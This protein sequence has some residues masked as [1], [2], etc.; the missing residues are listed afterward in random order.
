MYRIAYSQKKGFTSER[1]LLLSGPLVVRALRPASWDLLLLVT[2]GPPAGPPLLPAHQEAPGGSRGGGLSASSGWK[3]PS[4]VVWRSSRV[5]K[6]FP[7]WL[8]VS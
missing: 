4:Q 6:I 3:I 8:S 1:L 2:P 5:L 7:L